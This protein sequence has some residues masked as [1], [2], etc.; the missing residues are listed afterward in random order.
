M[1]A[2]EVAAMLE[3]LFRVR[4]GTVDFRTLGLAPRSFLGQPGYQFDFEHLDGD[5]VWRARPRGRGDGQRSALPHA[6]RRGAGALLRRRA[7]PT[8]NLSSIRRAFAPSAR[9]DRAGAGAAA[10]RAAAAPRPVRPAARRAGVACWPSADRRNRGRRRIGRRRRRRGYVDVGGRSAGSRCGASLGSAGSVGWAAPGSG[11]SSGRGVSDIRQTPSWGY[12]PV[13]RRKLPVP[14]EAI[15]EVARPA[16]LAIG[17]ALR[18][19]RAGVAELVDALVLGTSIARCGG[20]S[21]FA[22]TK[23]AAFP[24]GQARTGIRVVVTF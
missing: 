4:G 5:E 22:R 14:P 10:R 6:A 1:T 13:A 20:S 2:P 21:P 23:R 17:R 18:S 12:N 24:G 7:C 19:V 16:I 15:A 9:P 3:S 8:S 11:S